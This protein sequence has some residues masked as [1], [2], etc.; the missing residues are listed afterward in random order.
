[1][2]FYRDSIPRSCTTTKE[3]KRYLDELVASGAPWRSMKTIVLGNGQI[4]KTT[5]VG[6]LKNVLANKSLLNS[7][8]NFVKPNQVLYYLY[9][10]SFFISNI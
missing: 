9:N 3:I 7:V 4:G 2:K 10:L 1:M 6:H 5:F 8:Y